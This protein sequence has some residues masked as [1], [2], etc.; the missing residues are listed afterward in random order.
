MSIDIETIDWVARAKALAPR[1]AECALRIDNENGLPAELVRALHEAGM[2]RLLL[3]RS[4]GGFEIDLIAFAETIETLAMADASTAWCIGQNNGC[5]MS[6]AYLPLEAG[7][8][9][10]APG[11]V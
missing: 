7:R 2:Y 1:I 3:P 10:F 11:S 8:E 5:A 9:V 4:C 6:A